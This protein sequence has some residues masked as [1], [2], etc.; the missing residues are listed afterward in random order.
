MKIKIEMTVD[1]D[2]KVLRE[3]M[4]DLDVCGDETL[5][6]FVRSYIVSG[7]FGTLEEALFNNGYDSNAIELIKHNAYN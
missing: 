5:P 7:G 1:V 3:Y 2:T 4:R 6:E